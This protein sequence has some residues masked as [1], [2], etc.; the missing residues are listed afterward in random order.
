MDMPIN[1]FKAGLISRDCQIGLWSSLANSITAELICHA[2]YD[3][4][5]LDSEHGP[6]NELVAL[7]QLQAMQGGTA[8]PIIRVAVN[9][10]VLIK[11]ALDIG[12]QTIIVPQTETREDALAAVAACRY[13]PDGIRGVGPMARASRYGQIE[14]YLRKAEAEICVIAMCESRKGLANL[15]AIARTQGIDGVLVGPQDMAADLGYLGNHKAA[16]VVEACNL[17]VE[18]IRRAGKP[19]GIMVG[20]ETEAAEWIAKGCGFVGCGSD[21]ALLRIAAQGAAARLKTLAA[22]LSQLS[23]KDG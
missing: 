22:D 19:A 1:T 5:V 18:T 23:H 12:A 3:W 16:P 2:G 9:D 8:S 14:D 11:R 6:A 17:A 15:E 21:A 10:P 4:I 13:P 20:S 7:S